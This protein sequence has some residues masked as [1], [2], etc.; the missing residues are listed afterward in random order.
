MAVRFLNK[1]GL[2]YKDSN[3]E[4][5]SEE[6]ESFID[7]DHVYYDNKKHTIGTGASA[8]TRPWTLKDFFEKVSTF[9][10]KPMF[11]IY[12]KKENDNSPTPALN[13]ME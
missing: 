2:K 9:F 4:S 3:G 7:F 13:I 8:Q 5:Q 6:F 1:L 11:M 12:S 10:N